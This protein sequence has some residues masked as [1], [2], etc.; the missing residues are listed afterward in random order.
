MILLID[1]SDKENIS[2]ILGRGQK[3]F[4]EKKIQA[5]YAQEEKLLNSLQS[6]FSEVGIDGGDIEGIIVVKG[7]GSFS[8]LRIGLAVAN[9]LAWSWQIPIIGWAKHEF[10]SYAEIIKNF[11][12]APSPSNEF[13]PVMPYY[14]RPPNIG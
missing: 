7:P 13:I 10:G 14:D 8:A 6:I 2:L 1:T 5:F 12:E 4:L 9:A 11:Y 3:I